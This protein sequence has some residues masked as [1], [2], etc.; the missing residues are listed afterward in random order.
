M[1]VPP[2]SDS[3]MA[4][5]LKRIEDRGLVCWEAICDALEMLGF[6]L[7]VNMVVLRQR[8]MPR[9]TF[10]AEFVMIRADW[11]KRVDDLQDR[12]ATRLL[13]LD[14]RRPRINSHRELGH[15]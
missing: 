4:S 10:G 5:L 8:V 14:K 3:R 9:C 11:Q 13:D 7:Y 15:E 2:D 1:G 6:P 12:W